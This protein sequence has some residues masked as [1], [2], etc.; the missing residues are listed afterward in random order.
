[1]AI[2]ERLSR[3]PATL[4]EIAQPFG[5]T[6]AAIVQHVQVLEQCNLVKSEKTGRVRTCHADPRGLDIVSDWITKRRLTVERQLD[7]LGQILA[8]EDLGNTLYNTNT[9]RRI[10]GESRNRTPSR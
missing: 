9:K 4:S 1:M 5:L 8:D 6:L 2:V 7:R 10:H 3:G